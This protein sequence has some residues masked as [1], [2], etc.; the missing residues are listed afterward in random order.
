MLGETAVFVTKKKS[1]ECCQGID[2]KTGAQLILPIA[3]HSGHY[4]FSQKPTKNSKTQHHEMSR[5]P[6]E[7]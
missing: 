6:R 1:N 4:K 2:K 3:V 7:I 5:E